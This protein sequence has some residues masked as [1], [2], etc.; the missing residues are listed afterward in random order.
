ME[1]SHFS[2]GHEG[3]EVFWNAEHFEPI[4][5][6]LTFVAMAI[7]AYGVY[8]RWLMWTAIGKPENR[9]DDRKRPS[10]ILIPASCIR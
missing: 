9:A 1:L 5:F 4:L 7:F 2:I 6:A 3:R 8:R 10:P